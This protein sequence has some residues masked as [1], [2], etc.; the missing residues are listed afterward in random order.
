MSS[1]NGMTWQQA[2]MVIGLHF[3]QLGIKKLVEKIEKEKK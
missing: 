2:L 1:A 3:L